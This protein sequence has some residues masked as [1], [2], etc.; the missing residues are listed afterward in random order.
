[1]GTNPT[2][3][4]GNIYCRARKEAAK[5]NAMLNS[6]EGAAEVL[7]YNPSTLAGWELDT[8]NPSADAVAVMMEAYHAP[9]L[10]NHYCR[11]ICPLG[12]DTPVFKMYELDRITV[13]ALSAVRKV[14]SSK[15]LLLDI[16]ADGVI[17]AEERPILEEI[18][19]NL[20]EM[21][22]IAEALKNWARKRL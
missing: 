6:R 21:A 17:T 2:K 16:T 18:I 11:N 1:M 8:D 4:A 22:D 7:G 19:Q 14:N 3:A 5:Q 20:D 12:N 13:M 9:E 10:R 15:E